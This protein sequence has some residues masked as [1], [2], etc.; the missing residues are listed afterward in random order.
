[1]P[2]TITISRCISFVKWNFHPPVYGRL[3]ARSV[4]NRRRQ[5]HRRPRYPLTRI[6]P[7]Q[8]LQSLR[9]LPLP[10]VL[11]VPAWSA[12][13]LAAAAPPVLPQVLPE[14]AGPP[15]PPGDG[16]GPR[17]AL[18]RAG[19]RPPPPGVPVWPVKA[20]P[21]DAAGGSPV[22]TPPSDAADGSPV[23]APP[24]GAAGGSPVWPDG[25]RWPLPGLRGG[26]V[27]LRLPDLPGDVLRPLCAPRHRGD[28]RPEHGAPWLP[29]PARAYAPV[30]LSQTS[31][32]WL[33]AGR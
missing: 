9:P 6:N 18:T 24:S 19:K 23:K 3:P 17:G 30:L 10:R 32:S 1:M 21:S 22:R 33:R 5:Y 4:K 16:S 25:P 2:A 31:G 26:S 11:A 27:L 7:D 29:W 14:G 8:I 20:P 15:G 13:V 12:P 28:S